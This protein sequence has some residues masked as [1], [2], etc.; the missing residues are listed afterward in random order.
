MRFDD[1]IVL[2]TGAGSGIGK[3][4]ALTYFD[5]GAKVVVS[6]INEINGQSVCTEILEKGGDAIFIKADISDYEEVKSLFQEAINYFGQLDIAVNNAGMGSEITKTPRVKHQ[7]WDRVIA[8]NQTG[9]FYC[10]QEELA[11]MEKQGFGNIVNIA[12]MA[13]LKG[14]PRQI[15]YTASKHA[16]VGMTKAAALEY[17]RLPIRINAVCPVFTK[18]PMLDDLL[19]MQDGMDKKLMQ[20]I[21]LRRFGKT[22]EIVDAILWLSSNQASF[23]TGLALPVDGGQSA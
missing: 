8:V 14:L 4:A 22:E 10:M 3:Q 7:D 2:I 9:T 6:D 12:S 23:V 21:P 15:A 1:K 20:T 18:S 16:V 11:I 5:K 19:S 13:G 17:T